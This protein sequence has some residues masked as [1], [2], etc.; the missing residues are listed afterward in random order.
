MAFLAG[1]SIGRPPKRGLDALPTGLIV[2]IYHTHGWLAVRL[3]IRLWAS[4]LIARISE[5]ILTNHNCVSQTIEMDPLTHEPTKNFSLQNG[6]APCQNFNARN[7]RTFS[8]KILS[9]HGHLNDVDSPPEHL[10][11]ESLFGSSV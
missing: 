4:E 6:L 3:S 1:F 8:R 10:L 2:E 7:R 11:D 5:N 9:F